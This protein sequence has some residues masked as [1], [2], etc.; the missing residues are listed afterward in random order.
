MENKVTYV[1]GIYLKKISNGFYGLDI[2]MTKLQEQNLINER[3][4]IKLNISEKT[5]K[6]K[7]YEMDKFGKV[8]GDYKITLNTW[9][10]T[11]GDINPNEVNI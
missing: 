8:M 3:G 9:K 1:K 4:F 2:D 5:D 10:P 11:N 7:S 6:D